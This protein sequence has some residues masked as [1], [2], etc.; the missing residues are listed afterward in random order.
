[1]S[2]RPVLVT[3]AAGF[4]GGHLLARLARGQAPIVGWHRP[5][6][7]QR[8]RALEWSGADSAVNVTWQAVDVRDADAVRGAMAAIQPVAVYHCAGA[9]HL[10]HSWASTRQTLEANALTTH[11]ILHAVAI[12][13]PG[14]R[15][16]LPG[17]ATVYRA[18]ESALAEDAPVAPSSPYAVSKLAQEM[19]GRHAAAEGAHVVLPR[20]FNHTGPGQDPTFAASSFARQIAQIERGA[21][22]PVIAVGNL[23]ARREVMDVR[24]TV[25]AYVLLAQRG[26]SGRIYNVSTG[27]AVPVR[28]VLDRLLAL[29]SRRIEVRVDP[30]RLRPHDV[31]LLQG[32]ATR[33]QAELGWRPAHTIDD[34]LERLLQYWRETS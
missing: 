9:A 17:S 3:G 23:E 20:A 22:E 5:G 11:F 18:S 7:R 19:I 27:Q 31:P 28:E 16:L 21:A 30:S 2:E 25:D 34:T 4:V 33:L 32:D 26:P 13:A 12:A 10:G 24:D 8:P 29:S 1:V 6:G 15:V 14:A